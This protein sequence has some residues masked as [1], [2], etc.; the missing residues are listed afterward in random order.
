MASITRRVLG[1]AMQ[2][3]R[4][5]ALHEAYFFARSART[6]AKPFQAQLAAWTGEQARMRA[7]RMMG[8]DPLNT[9]A[10]AALSKQVTTGRSSFHDKLLKQ[11]GEVI[12]HSIIR[13]LD[14]SF[15]RLLIQ[16]GE[17]Q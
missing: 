2:G 14:R 3:T 16:L 12:H 9:S 1:N 13:D 8:K 11:D 10:L 7:V 17:L 4:K 5:R 15:E 6:L